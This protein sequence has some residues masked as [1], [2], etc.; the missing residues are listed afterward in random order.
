MTNELQIIPLAELSRLQTISSV[1]AEERA[2]LFADTCRINTLYMIMK[3]GSGHPGSSLSCLDIVSWIYLEELDNLGN[4]NSDLFFSSK[5]HDVPGIY[6]VLIGL[7]LLPF[8]QLHQLRK[9]GGLPGHPDIHTPHIV[10]NTGSLGMGISKAKGMVRVHRL[11]GLNR[12][13]FVLLGDGELQEGQIWESLL[14]ATHAKMGEITVIVDHNKLQSDTFVSEVSDLGDLEMRFASHGWEVM[15]CDGHDLCEISKHLQKLNLITD[16]PKVLIADTIKAK[17][18]EQM[19]SIHFSKDD[20]LYKFHSGA[21]KNEVYREAIDFL[22]KSI[23]NR[24]MASGEPQLEVTSVPTTVP[25]KIGNTSQSLISAYSSA[26]QKQAEQR[27]ELIVLSADL[28]FDTGLIDF[29]NNFPE[30]FVE[31]GIAEQDMVSQAGG[32]ALW[33]GLPVV[34]SFS[35]FLTTRANEQI[36]NNAT[37]EKRIVYVGSLAGLLPGMPGHSHQSVRDIAL[38][39]QI[40]GMLMIEPSCEKEVEEALEYCLNHQGPSYLRLTSIPVELPY[41]LPEN[42]KLK[43]G[44]GVKLRDGGDLLVVAYGPVLLAEAIRAAHILE[45][46]NIEVCVVNLPWLNTVDKKWLNELITPFQR[47]VI[48]DNH[49]L[50]GGQGEFLNRIMTTEGM[51]AEK[52]IM[53]HGLETIPACG[54]H[55]EVLGFH[56]MDAASLLKRFTKF[57]KG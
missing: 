26:L 40:P 16:L 49:Y 48:L 22:I 56:D 18:A 17:G 11:Q 52:N 30:R 37:E 27:P 24:L 25:M 39:S 33:G 41:E 29:E 6:S 54:T 28:A 21:P 2:S 44:Q 12:K 55:H 34:H 31:C 1:T 47:L 8:E 45:K 3:A 46:D 9:L 53:L 36:Y 4:E 51:L 10:T 5:G 32:M 7:G 57:M 42:S 19:E 23:N 15:R 20:R 35:C 13:I 43:L 50:H 14:S 38:L